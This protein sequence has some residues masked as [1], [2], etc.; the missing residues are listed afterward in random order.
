[1]Q[2]KL[3]FL[4]GSHL[5][6]PVI[7]YARKKGYQVNVC[8]YLSDNPG[9]NYADAYYNVSTTDVD[10][11]LNLARDLNIDGIVV[12]ASDP[13][14]ATAAYVAEKLGLPGNPYNSVLTLSRKDL[15]RQ[16]L[17]SHGFNAPAAA[18]FGS[19]TEAEA[20][21]KSVKLPVM[22]KPVDS[23]GSKGVSKITSFN[24][25]K[26]AFHKAI[27]FS[28]A[29]KVIIEQY[30]V[31]KG[32]QIAGDGLI[33]NGKLAFRCFAQEHFEDSQN[34]F[35]PIG[36]SFPLQLPYVIQNKIHEEV[37]RLLSLLQMQMGAINFD[38]L[39]DENDEV[40][41]MEVGPRAGGNLISEMIKYCTGADIVECIVDGAAGMQCG[42]ISENEVYKCCSSFILHSNEGGIFKGVI[43]DQSL[44]SNVLKTLLFVE[45]GMPVKPFVDSGGTLG[46]VLLK[47]DSPGEM[48]EK[49][50]CITEL[51]HVEVV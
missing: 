2:K 26:E 38:I 11:V 5:Q 20:Y 16:F 35:T 39:L 27:Q 41:L 48:L 18:G 51:V 37:Q 10:S 1:M 13:A 33:I 14:A 45:E 24:Q 3:L 31:R 19:F 8:D 34:H 43:I 4:G 7:L 17:L 12:Y 28:R 9:Q 6:L 49:M 40:Y 23:S 46:C 29:K 50:K 42:P 30:V 44:E 21:V 15:Y 47:F 22:I 32:F 25:F 36:E